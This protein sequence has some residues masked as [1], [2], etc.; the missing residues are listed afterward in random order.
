MRIGSTADFLL[1]LGVAF[2]FL[3]PP[4]NAFLDP[5]AWVGYFP[6]FV[7]DIFPEM[8]VLHVFGLIEIVIGLWILSGRRI[9]IP[10]VVGA[11]LLLLIV[12]F[13]MGDFQVLFRDVS[14]AFMAL[15]LAVTHRPRQA[16]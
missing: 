2:A 11:A 15:A 8:V 7:G 3:F 12:A 1:R 14:I 10:S 6:S 9:F 5:Y 16:A 4:V 13:N